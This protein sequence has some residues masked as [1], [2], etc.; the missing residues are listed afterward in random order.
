MDWRACGEAIGLRFSAA[1]SGPL[2][3]GWQTQAPAVHVP[4]SEQSK[5][6]LHAAA[7][8]PALLDSAAEASQ[9]APRSR[10]VEINLMDT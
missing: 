7:G 8:K 4:A 1:Q 9:A 5:S 2:V 3:Q 6:D 10:H